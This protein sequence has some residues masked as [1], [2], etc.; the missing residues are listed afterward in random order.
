MHRE[1][2]WEFTTLCKGAV[3][4]LFVCF[5]RHNLV[6]LFILLLLG[7]FCVFG[8]CGEEG[9]ERQVDV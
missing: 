7:T 8:G 6:S 1:P 2:A 9:G 4:F 3:K 5:I